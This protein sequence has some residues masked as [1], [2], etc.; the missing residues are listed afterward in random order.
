MKNAM[1]ASSLPS[2]EFRETEVKSGFNSVRVVLRNSIKLRKQWVDSEAVR[3]L[4]PRSADLLQ[5]ELRILNFVSEHGSIN[6][7]QSM[8]LVSSPRKWQSVKKL[9]DG[10][11]KKNLLQ[12][13]HS[14]T[15]ERDS[16]A[17]YKLPDQTKAQ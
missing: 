17:C 6:V 16:H 15:I 11:V 5:S 12:H 13:H 14:P 7:T 10:M 4:G 9:L 1:Q 3:V 2:P 8:R